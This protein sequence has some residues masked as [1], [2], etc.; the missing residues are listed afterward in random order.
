MLDYAGFLFITSSGFFTADISIFSAA[1]F[2]L[3]VC[4]YSLAEFFSQD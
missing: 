2:H 1:S 3:N 4:V